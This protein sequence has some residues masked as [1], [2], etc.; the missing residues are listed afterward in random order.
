MAGI[1]RVKRKNSTTEE[2]QRHAFYKMTSDM[3]WKNIRRSDSVFYELLQRDKKLLQKK[4]KGVTHVDVYDMPIIKRRKSF[5]EASKKTS[6][7]IV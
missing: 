7:R 4:F 1:K 3:W 2:L 6:R 5:M